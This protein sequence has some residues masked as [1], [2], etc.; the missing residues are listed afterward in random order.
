MP[1]TSVSINVNLPS[2]IPAHFNVDKIGQ[3]TIR[4]GGLWFR[5]HGAHKV[6]WKLTWPQFVKMMEDHCKKA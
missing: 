1:K 4:P 6:K 5:P 2:G 3:L